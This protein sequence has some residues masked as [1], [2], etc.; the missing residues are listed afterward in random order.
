M[1]TRGG[2]SPS[3]CS[4]IFACLDIWVEVRASHCYRGKQGCFGTASSIPVT[5]LERASAGSVFEPG[6]LPLHQG[7][8]GSF[9]VQP[10]FRHCREGGNTVAERRA[11]FWLA[12]TE[13]ERINSGRQNLTNT[14]QNLT[15]QSHKEPFTWN[16][17][18]TRQL[19]LMPRQGCPC[20]SL[21]PLAQVRQG[22]FIPLY[23]HNSWVWTSAEI[24]GYPPPAKAQNN[25]FTKAF[26]DQPGNVHV[27]NQGVSIYESIRAEF[28]LDT[29]S[30]LGA[31][32]G[33]PGTVKSPRVKLRD[34]ERTPTALDT[35]HTRSGAECT[36]L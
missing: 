6:F 16:R 12:T 36:F 7:A 20:C 19:L 9:S 23:L 10:P 22:L 17:S 8:S 34:T 1:G 15:R 18:L 13:R 26:F 25:L 21:S 33:S 4:Q 11:C 24:P 28:M 5:H 30:S 14:R 3:R 31:D 35:L 27:F 2:K 32:C 29:P